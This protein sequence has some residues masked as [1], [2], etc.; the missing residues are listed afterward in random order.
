MPYQRIGIAVVE[1]AGEYLVGTRGP[2]GP[3]PGCAEFPGGKCL[4][5]ETPRDC[6]IRECREETGLAVIAE[7]LLL[8]CRFDYPHGPV[9]LHFWLC[10]PA[11]PSQRA[12]AHHGFRW[13]PAEQLNTLPFPAANAALLEL[14]RSA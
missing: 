2:D 6:A 1:L 14:L 10:R 9:E 8:N 13:V 3:L 12:D 11:D 4:P 5:D 7:R